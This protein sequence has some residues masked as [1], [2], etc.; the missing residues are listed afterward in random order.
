MDSDSL[1]TKMYSRWRDEGKVIYDNDDAF[2][3][4]SVTPYTP[5]QSLVIPR[6]NVKRLTL[7]KVDEQVAFIRALEETLGAVKEIY[8][9]DPER[10]VGFYESL[11]RNSDMP[12]SAEMAKKMLGHRHL[13]IP[14]TSSYNAGI[15]Y[16]PLAGQTMPHIHAHIVPRREEGKG[17]LTAMGPLVE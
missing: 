4:L 2:S 15:N 7:L 9:E 13:R 6:R 3:I 14:P 12:Q 10:I 5:G 16:G 17:F 8:E 11:A 1:F